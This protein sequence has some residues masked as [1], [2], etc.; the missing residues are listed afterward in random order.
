M[1]S[2]MRRNLL[3]GSQPAIAL[4]LVDGCWLY[5]TVWMV[6]RVGFGPGASFLL[7]QPLLLAAVEVGGWAVTSALLERGRLSERALRTVMS[8][9]GLGFGLALAFAY[10]PIPSQLS[11]LYVVP[12]LLTLFLV[13]GV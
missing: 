12:F 9:L 11:A 10:N 5:I 7:P 3:S 6:A 13:L 2:A 1:N 4:A 8:L